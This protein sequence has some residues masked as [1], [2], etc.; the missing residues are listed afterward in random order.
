MKRN[1]TITSVGL[2]ALLAGGCT[3]APRYVQPEAPV[4]AAWPEPVAGADS[5]TTAPSAAQ[6]ALADFLPDQRLQQLIG[7]ALAS[8]RDL[9]LAALNMDRA[10]ELYHI[11]R[12][13][14][15]PAI[16]A[17]G[18]ASRTHDPAS[19]S[20]TG[21]ENTS[22]YY[23]VDVGVTSWEIDFFGR[24]RSLKNAALEQYLAT[25][26][27]RRAAQLALQSHVAAAWLTLAADRDLLSL[28]DSTLAA[29]REIAGMIA[30]RQDVGLASEIDVRRAQTQADAARVVAA[31]AR[32]AV[33]QDRNALDLLAGTTVPAEL[34]PDGWSSL[35]LP[36]A[37]SAGL[38]S[39]VLLARPDVM[40][41]E[42]QLKAANANVG[43][44][45]AAFFP[46]IS[47]TALAGTA[48]SALSG[49][50][51]GDAKSWSFVGQATLPIFDARTMAA[52][53]ASKADR[54][55]AQAQYE[56][57]IQAAFRE[58]ADA[59]AVQASVDEQLSAREALLD[60][61]A[62][63]YRLARERN[64]A[65]LDNYLSVLDAQRS[66]FAVQQGLIATRL[67]KYANLVNLYAI[68]GGGE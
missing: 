20:M 52:A 23:S 44:A 47:L 65:G 42:H 60:G 17:A 50:F 57:T 62:V 34:L 38:P 29:Q 55:M 10:R 3:L 11:K 8:N 32:Q 31:S 66:L 12:N 45:R 15:L 51:K 24:V 21:A 6:V 56:K 22:E 59:L 5:L 14:L 61:A 26:E 46:R 37:I 43:A 4:P 28:A 53:K 30:R 58:V 27:A 2:L 16:G 49:L 36:T 63:T 40:A 18:Y 39:D 9:R 67:G 33:A 48:S 1:T 35:R 68:T 64:D 54:A 7:L 13:E 25:A 19:V 41:A